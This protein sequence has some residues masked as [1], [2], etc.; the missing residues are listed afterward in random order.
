MSNFLPCWPSGSEL[1]ETA[2]AVPCSSGQTLC[3]EIPLDIEIHFFPPLLFKNW[4]A[5]WFNFFLLLLLGFVLV[6][7]S[8]KQVRKPAS[9][10]PFLPDVQKRLVIFTNSGFHSSFGNAENSIGTRDTIILIASIT[11]VRNASELALLWWCR[12][13]LSAG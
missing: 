9:S 6:F 3:V 4:V 8:K 11:T 10:F 12:S 13:H 1:K 2:W 5:S 7:F